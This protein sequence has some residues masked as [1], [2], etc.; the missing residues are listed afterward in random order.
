MKKFVTSYRCIDNWRI[1]FTILSK[2]EIIDQQN[3]VTKCTKIKF[4]EH[5][6]FFILN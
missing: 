1:S 3:E 4:I 2:C 6:L 5:F